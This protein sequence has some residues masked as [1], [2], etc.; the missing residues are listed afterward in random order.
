MTVMIEALRIRRRKEAR[1]TCIEGHP[2]IIAVTPFN[3]SLSFFETFNF[4]FKSKIQ[5][6]VL[7]KFTL[8]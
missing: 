2:K 8:P 4:F 3:E 5:F 1:R 7:S 6:V